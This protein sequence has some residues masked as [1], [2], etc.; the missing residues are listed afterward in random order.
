[1][2]DTAHEWTDTL[3]WGDSVSIET[4]LRNLVYFIQHNNSTAHVSSNV[5]KQNFTS[6][7][8]LAPHLCFSDFFQKFK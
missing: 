5:F 1:M 6:H 8:N 4:L 7:N 2:D 3:P